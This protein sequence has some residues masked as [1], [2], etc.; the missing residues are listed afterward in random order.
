[1]EDTSRWPEFYKEA[2][3]FHRSF[4]SHVI[5]A[6]P[7][8]HMLFNTRAPFGT[9]LPMLPR[10]KG[11]AAAPIAA[12]TGKPAV[13]D[14]FQGPVAKELLVAIAVPVVREGKVR[15]LLLTVFEARQFQANLEQVAL[16]AGWSLTLLDGSGAA[17]ARRA[18][19]RREAGADVDAG[20]RF[21]AKSALSPWSVVLEVPSDIRRAPLREAA[22]AL[23]LAVVGATVVGLVGGTLAGRRLARSVSSLVQAPVPG[24]QPPRI[25]EIASV[26]SL[27]DEAARR[28]QRLA[29]IVESSDDAIVSSTI[30]GTITSWNGGAERMFGYTAG[31]AIGRF[32]RELIRPADGAAAR[33][34]ERRVFNTRRCA[35]P[36]AAEE[37]VRLH[38][39]GH[40]IT[41]S[42]VTGT[43][44]DESGAVSEV[45]AIMRDITLAQ[46][47]DAELQ[48]LLAEQQ[49]RERLMRDLTARLRTLREEECTRISRDVHDGLGQLLTC[50]KME[51][52]WMR[53]RVAAGAAAQDLSAKLAETETLV[54]QTVESVQKIAV[55]LRPSVLDALGLPAA[56]RDEARRFEAR[57]GVAASVETRTSELPG[58]A[59]ATALFRILQEL[60]TN[61]ARHAGASSLRITLEDDEGAW[62][63][64]VRD[65][66]VGIPADMANSATSLGLLGMIER[67]DAIGGTFRIERAPQG[68]TLATVSVPHPVPSESQPACGT[69]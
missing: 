22:G 53:R 36:A 43:I 19:P 56:I 62:V 16:P 26:R 64:S 8:M 49:A 50:L 41:L 68:G 2:Q 57:T 24:A 42:V 61:I 35:G 29:A 55:E 25:A 5:L 27:L 47:R 48:R 44:R 60:L 34:P 38:K 59:V 15:Q 21:S 9:T 69:S 4:G 6:D 13:G 58:P 31:E 32:V 14:S 17:I 30:D 23:A 3:G 54:D 10:P 45:A 37:M 39:D 46:R 7:Q 63:L 51:I 66:G 20:G 40:P 65:D 33:V 11:R 67:A 1:V 18:P 12:E 28:R 52:R